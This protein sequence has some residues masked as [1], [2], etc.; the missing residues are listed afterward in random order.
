[1]DLSSLFKTGFILTF[2]YFM[3][4]LYDIFFS[5]A[6]KRYY[7]VLLM[8]ILCPILS[9]TSSTKIVNQECIETVKV[10]KVISR[11]PSQ[12]LIAVGSDNITYLFPNKTKLNEDVCTTVKVDTETPYLTLE[13]IE[14]KKSFFIKRSKLADPLD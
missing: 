5:K 6:K 9:R 10:I 12:K 13:G 1:M 2:L 14:N 3:F 11:K 8:S 4:N 7:V